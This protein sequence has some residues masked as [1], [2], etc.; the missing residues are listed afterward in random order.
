MLA[1]LSRKG[2]GKKEVITLREIL[3]SKLPEQLVAAGDLDLAG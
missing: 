1:T 2:R 3:F